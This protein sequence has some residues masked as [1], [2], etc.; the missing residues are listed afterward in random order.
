MPDSMTDLDWDEKK[1]LNFSDNFERQRNTIAVL[2]A[3]GPLWRS[4]GQSKTQQRG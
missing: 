1:E 4:E 2:P 3:R